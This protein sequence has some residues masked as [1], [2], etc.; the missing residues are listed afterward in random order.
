MIYRN[1]MELRSTA[2]ILKYYNNAPDKDDIIKLKNNA[3][4]LPVVPQAML[5]VPSMSS[6]ASQSTNVQ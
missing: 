4:F 6:I 1:A 3:L 5:P 2:N